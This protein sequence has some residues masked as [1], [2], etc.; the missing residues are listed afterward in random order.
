MAQLRRYAT[1]RATWQSYLARHDDT[2]NPREITDADWWWPPDDA[3]AR[4]T[5]VDIAN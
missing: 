4:W 1:Q 5:L 2:T 3:V